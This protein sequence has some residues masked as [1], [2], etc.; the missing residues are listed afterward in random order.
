MANIEI[1]FE[2]AKTG[3]KLLQGFCDN[4]AD[5]SECPF[6]KSVVISQYTVKDFVIYKCTIGN[7]C[8]YDYDNKEEKNNE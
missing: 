5:C 3:I 1:T 7:P 8:E 4:F 6:S 2:D